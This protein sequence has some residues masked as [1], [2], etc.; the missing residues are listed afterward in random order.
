MGTKNFQ[1]IIYKTIRS[2]GRRLK[3]VFDDTDLSRHY[4]NDEPTL[5]LTIFLINRVS[6]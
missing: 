4:Y 3:G 6:L 1:E 5:N 2:S